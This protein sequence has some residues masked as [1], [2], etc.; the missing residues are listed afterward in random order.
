M[1]F[2]GHISESAFLV[3]ES[4]AR[5]V[6]LSKD[7]Y[8]SLWVTESTRRLWDDFTSEVYPH[9]EIELGLRNR[10]FLER[11]GS[12]VE[13][14]SAPAFINI[15]AGFTSYP[16]LIDKQI[17]CVE[18]D[19]PHVAAFKRSRVE[20]MTADGILPPRRVEF[21]ACDL[22]SL[23]DRRALA[24]TLKEYAGTP[25]FIL[26]EGLTY[27]LSRDLL[28]ELLGMTR[29][30]QIDGS[31]LAFDF[32]EPENAYS[33][34][35]L[36]FEKFFA[37]RFGVKES[38][39]NFVDQGFVASIEGYRVAEIRSIQELETL[40]SDTRALQDPAEILPESYALLTKGA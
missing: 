35:F 27:Y 14:H 37:K 36:R 15:G 34:V 31:A 40:F 9:D 7:R 1:S 13:S 2:D 8:A 16:F 3:N 39:Y 4:R 32:W 38:K 5:R 19:Y 23:E 30:V 11:L 21:A 10:F 26:M 12:F 20:Q 17:P 6:G 33:P 25:T 29:A 24:L 18:V 22:T 28:E